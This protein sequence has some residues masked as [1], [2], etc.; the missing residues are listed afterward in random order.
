MRLQ[1]RI[2]R[3]PSPHE[4]VVGFPMSILAV[5]SRLNSGCPVRFALGSMAIAATL[6]C[7]ACSAGSADEQGSSASDT[8]PSEVDLNG[9]ALSVAS[10]SSSTTDASTSGACGKENDLAGCQCAL[11]ALGTTQRCYP[12]PAKQAGVGACVWG[13]QR[14]DKTGEFGT[15]SACEGAGEPS[16]EKCDGIDHDCDGT[17]D[18]GCACTTGAKR[19]CYGGPPGTEGVGL[20]H[21][22]T[23]LCAAGGWGKCVGEVLPTPNTCD[24]L[25]HLCNKAPNVGCACPPGT[26][27]ACYDGPAG[28]GGVGSTWGAC[29]G[30]ALPTPAAC[31]GIDHACNKLPY[32]TCLCTP[33]QTRSCY[34][35]PAATA[36]VGACHAGMQ[37]CNASGTAWSTTCAGEVLPSAE[38]CFDLIDQDCDGKPDEGCCSKEAYGK[39]YPPDVLTT[40]SFTIS[41]PPT[42]YPGINLDAYLMSGGWDDCGTIG[43]FTSTCTL[44]VVATYPGPAVFVGN[45]RSVPATLKN[46]LAGGCG[47][48]ATMNWC[49]PGGPPKF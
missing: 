19:N 38:I 9:D 15:W 36:G 40:Y 11:L 5:V 39:G 12:G 4:K 30:E 7:A 13:T 22:G 44:G 27:E 21:G 10:D 42:L 29:V 14:C 18:E 47:Y 43:T 46:I 41:A 26:V 8:S 32:A 2:F 49:M 45:G 3:E 31:D 17:A 20:C 1:G 23:Q 6:S 25:D 24:G 35:G 16:A 33:G 34:S 37:T 48:N 28:P